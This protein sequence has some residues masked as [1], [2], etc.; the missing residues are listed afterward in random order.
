LVPGVVFADLLFVFF[1]GN[2]E[3]FAKQDW[4]KYVL[5]IENSAKFLVLSQIQEIKAPLPL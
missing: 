3:G 4:P 1:L 5:R 2:A